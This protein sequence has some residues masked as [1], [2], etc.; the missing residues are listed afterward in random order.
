MALYFITGNENKLEEVR[1]IL[2]DVLRL[3]IDLPEIQDIDPKEIVKA[4]LM[5]AFKHRSGGFIIEDTSLYL[6]CLNGLPGPLIKW[7][8]KA[9]G[10]EGL[11]R[12][13]DSFGNFSAE[14]KTII[15]YAED[16]Q[17]IQFFEGSVKGKIVMPKGESNFGW[18]PIFQP[19]DYD[20]TFA[21]MEKVEKNKISMRR[22]ALEKLKDF[23]TEKIG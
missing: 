5:D 15:G 10:N 14:A 16:P 13:A 18:D 2:P 19:E 22:I 9:I 6:N 1:A 17:N 4:K 20:K 3:D 12:I 8:L 7:F 23:I 21:E 11:F